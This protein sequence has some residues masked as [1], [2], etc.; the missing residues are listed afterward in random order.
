MGSTSSSNNYNDE[1]YNSI[2]YNN[3]IAEEEF[4]FNVDFINSFKRYKDKYLIFAKIC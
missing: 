4:I 1:Y 2:Y 3:N